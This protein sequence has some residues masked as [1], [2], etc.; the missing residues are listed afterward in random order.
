MS[1]AQRALLYKL[2]VESGLRARELA[3]L[4]RVTIAEREETNKRSSRSK[5]PSN[6]NMR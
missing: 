4:K 6:C 3:A 2:A 1:G 5:T